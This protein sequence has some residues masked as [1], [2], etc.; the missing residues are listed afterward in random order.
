MHVWPH[1]SPPGRG[2]GNVGVPIIARGEGAWV[3]DTEGKRYYDALSALYCVN[4]GYGRREIAEAMARQAEQL[5]YFPIWGGRLTIPAIELAAK[6]IELAPPRMDQVFFTGGGSESVDAA[7]KM[8]RQYH[9]LR[10]NPQKTKV[11]AREGAYHGTSMGALS[12]TGIPSIREPFEPLIPGVLHA[13]KVDPFH[14]EESAVDHSI[15]CANRL[16]EM[17]EEEGPESVGAI[18]V[19][20]VQNS[21][22]CLVAEP[23]YFNL[24][25]ETADEHDLLLVADETICAWGRLGEFFGCQAIGFEP[26]VITTAKGL[27]SGYAPMGAVI[28]SDAVAS[29]FRDKDEAFA[30]GLTYGG[31]PVA[32]VAALTTI[33]IMEEER[34]CERA[35]ETGQIFRAALEGLYDMPIVGDVRGS[36]MFHAVELVADASSKARFTPEQTQVLQG[37]IPDAI[38]EEGV[39]CR[40]IHRGAPLLQFA[41]HVN[42]TE[43]DL[44]D[45]VASTRRVL[46]RAS[47]VL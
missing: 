7:W 28:A 33:E 22:G 5:N 29:V 10:G 36:G 23:E 4:I 12:I 35:R 19:E 9:R 32:A 25:R 2:S 47:E 15:S 11:V 39:I 46:E 14:S 45:V 8:V 24:L 3:Y 30:H 44:V 40:A 31:H 6:V 37:L 17:I 13:P 34:L 41:P 1:F 38:I 21:G 27:T 42:A 18:F 43:S 26:D 16:R 20:P